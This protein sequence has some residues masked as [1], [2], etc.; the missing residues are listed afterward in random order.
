VSNLVLLGLTVAHLMKAPDGG[1]T[2]RQNIKTNIGRFFKLF[3]IL[4]FY[5]TGDILSIALALEYGQEKTCGFRIFADLTGLFSGVLLFLVLVCNK[6][7]LR[8]LCR[9]RCRYS[10]LN[11]ERDLEPQEMEETRVSDQ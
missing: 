5:W 3:I 6:Q 11:S 2:K 10:W 4:G 7:V 1:G 8:T 9:N